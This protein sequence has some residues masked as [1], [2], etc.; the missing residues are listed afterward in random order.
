M[1]R[2]SPAFSPAAR[3][4]RQHA[5]ASLIALHDHLGEAVIEAAG[6]PLLRLVAV[7]VAVSE[8]DDPPARDLETDR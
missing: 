6:A 2:A 4:Q 7:G 1:I 5:R 3:A 8:A